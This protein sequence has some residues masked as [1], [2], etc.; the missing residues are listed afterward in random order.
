MTPFRK[1]LQ[2][3]SQRAKAALLDAA[4]EYRGNYGTH[5]SKRLNYALSVMGV[6]HLKDKTLLSPRVHAAHS[7]QVGKQY[8]KRLAMVSAKAKTSDKSKGFSVGAQFRFLTLIHCLEAPSLSRVYKAIAKLRNDL[9]KATESSVGIWL[10]GAIEV[11][12]ISLEMMRQIS[13]NRS[14]SE[15]RK[16]DVCEGLLDQ[17]P[18][19]MR[20]QKYYFLIHFHGIAQA[21]SAQKFVDYENIL[22]GNKTWRYEPRQIQLKP[23]SVHYGGKRKT[24]RQSLVDIARYITKGGND[25]VG[26][27]AYLRYKLGF[28]NEV[29]E[30][31]DGWVSK[32]RKRNS[33]LRREHSEDG[34]TDPLAMT[35]N[36]IGDLAQ[37]IDNMMSRTADRTGY[38]LHAK[39]R[40]SP[41]NDL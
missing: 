6:H 32:N 35:C 33:Q 29:V 37:I 31:E 19:P 3:S 14:V 16:A 20:D 27:K 18:P 13:S 26:S 25:W 28:D 36:E 10:L 39:S 5:N 1:S 23:L 22:R 21:S 41:S 2:K 4:I 24:T 34:I 12:V 17:L 7:E 40:R 11:E 9:I 8:I 15:A 38:L 30:T